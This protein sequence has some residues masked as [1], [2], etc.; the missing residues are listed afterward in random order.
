MSF[1]SLIHRLFWKS[2]K[3]EIFFANI[4]LLKKLKI[5]IF[6]RLFSCR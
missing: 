2:E 4:K 3:K 1:F 5:I 6:H